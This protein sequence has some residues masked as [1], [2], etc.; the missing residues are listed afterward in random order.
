MILFLDRNNLTGPDNYESTKFKVMRAVGTTLT[1]V[2]RVPAIFLTALSDSGK[3]FSM[4]FKVHMDHPGYII[5]DTGGSTWMAHWNTQTWTEFLNINSTDAAAQR[6]GDVLFLKSITMSHFTSAGNFV[7]DVTVA[8]SNVDVGISDTWFW[9]L[10]QSGANG[11]VLRVKK[12]DLSIESTFAVTGGDVTA[13]ANIDVHSDTLIFIAQQVSTTT[14]KIFKMEIAGSVATTTVLLDTTTVSSLDGNET[15]NKLFHVVGSL[16]IWGGVSPS[17]AAGKVNYIGFS[18][19]SNA[20]AL[21]TVVSDLC[22]RTGLTDGDLDV[23]ALTSD[24][25][26]G[27]SIGRELTVR[28]MLAPL[29][30]AFSFDG[31]ES[32]GKIKF[33][34]RGGSSIETIPETQLAAR[35]PSATIPDLVTTRRL[36]EKELPREVN[37]LYK[38][39]GNDHQ[40]G[41]QRAT[42]LIT[43][44]DVVR[45]LEVP[46]SMSDDDA[47]Q[48][49]DILLYEAWLSRHE[50]TIQVSRRYQFLDPA[51]VITVTTSTATFI[52]RIIEQ[53]FGEPGILMLRC[54]DEQAAAFISGATGGT[55]DPTQTP[56]ALV[57][58]T[59]MVLLDIPLLRD[60]DDHPGF[61]AA[62]RGFTTIWPGCVLFRSLDGGESFNQMIPV[63]SET[64]IGEAITVLASGPTTIFDEVSTVTVRLTGGTLSST[65]EISVLNGSNVC[66]VGAEV[67]QFKTATLNGDGDYVLS[68]LLR[69][70]R[71]TEQHIGTHAVGDRFVLLQESTV[72]DIMNS[73]SEIGIARVFKAPTI[74]L[75]LE[76]A[77]QINFTDN[78]IRLEPLS[79]VHVTATRDVPATDDITFAW[80]RRGRLG[81][82]WRDLVDV[83][84][85]EATESYEVDIIDDGGPPLSPFRL[86]TSTSESVVYTAAQQTTDFGSPVASVHVKIYQISADVNRGF[87]TDFTG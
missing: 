40:Q 87:E 63:L 68:G 11:E 24:N 46:L 27:Y 56:P 30:T 64:P 36:N 62:A 54:L 81:P 51:D 52:L 75:R 6:G 77:D 20:I 1:N 13:M 65:T 76:E 42:R 8:T 37:I 43:K 74:G 26:S 69:A 78:G 38:N 14:L 67:L 18:L 34:K 50:R 9:R 33:I 21:S 10:S 31:L 86:L 61:Y 47:R 25:V 53:S 60:Q 23:T 29:Q 35:E 71:G 83:P 73:L 41:G 28:N 48:L 55:S 4:P 7:G 82:E 17:A 58:S 44:S 12:S 2:A 57:G 16:V 5:H 70:R 15:G 32:D 22:K 39:N 79:V 49:A 84:L 19:S 3:T 72:R 45:S 59:L 85:G 66:I 80:I